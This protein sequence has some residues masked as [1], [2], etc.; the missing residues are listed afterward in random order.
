MCKK[1]IKYKFGLFWYNVGWF[2]LF[3]CPCLWNALTLFSVFIYLFIFPLPNRI[4]SFN[5]LL[6]AGI[7]TFPRL[8]KRTVQIPRLALGVGQCVLGCWFWYLITCLVFTCFPDQLVPLHQLMVKT[9]P[10][11]LLADDNDWSPTTLGLVVLIA[12]PS[13]VNGIGWSPPPS[14]AAGI[15]QVPII[16]WWYQL[17]PFIGSG[18]WLISLIGWWYWLTPLT[19]CG[20]LSNSTSLAAGIN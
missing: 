4:N 6:A 7:D 10:H 3:F 11:P 13:L 18:N 1:E 20:Y 16:S 2:C 5:S 15:D 8:G 14:L 12:H 17:I 9:A 19:G